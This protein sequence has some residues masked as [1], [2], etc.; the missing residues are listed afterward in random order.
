MEESFISE[1]ILK[2]E[3]FVN[4]VLKGDLR[5]HENHL[6]QVNREIAE[7]VELRSMIT[8]IEEADFGPDGFKTKVDVGCNFYMQANVVQ[9]NKL[10][11]DIGLGNY[12]ELTTKEALKFCEM[13]ISLLTNKVKVIQREC[14]KTKGHIKLVLHGICELSNLPSNI[15]K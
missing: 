5:R 2:F 6:D 3:T 10:F 8:T 12:V 7:Y 15:N 11:V 1:K 14:A 13:R 4:D 9:P